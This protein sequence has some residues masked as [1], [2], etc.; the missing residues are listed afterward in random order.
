[1]EMAVT[2]ALPD[3]KKNMPSHT[4]HIQTVRRKDVSGRKSLF[5]DAEIQDSKYIARQRLI[6]QPTH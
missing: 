3:P 4:D 6:A 1:M 2:N 5:L